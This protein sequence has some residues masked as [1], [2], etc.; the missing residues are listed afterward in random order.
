MAVDQRAVRS[1]LV[2]AY[3]SIAPLVDD[4]V[5]MLEHVQVAHY[6]DYADA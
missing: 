5:G 1:Y 4:A 3:Y 6:H 2:S